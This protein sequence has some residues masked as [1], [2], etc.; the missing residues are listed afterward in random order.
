VI[1][2]L[3]VDLVAVDDLRARMLRTASFAD[4]VFDPVE[5][6]DSEAD[7]APWPHLAARFAAKE[8]VMKA[9]GTGWSAGVGHRDVVVVRSASGAPEVRLGGEA[10]RRVAAVSGRVLLTLT[11]QGDWAVA[12]AV[13][14]SP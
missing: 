8:A 2:G 13:I 14:E 3:G 7:G 10:A 6:S 11:H 9:L 4:A 5:R 12:V 1:L